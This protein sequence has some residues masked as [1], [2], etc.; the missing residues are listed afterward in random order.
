MKAALDDFLRKENSALN[1]YDLIAKKVWLTI[2]KP[3]PEAGQFARCL[4]NMADS[5]TKGDWKVFY[6]HP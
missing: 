3:E 1:K 4:K 6:K 2:D 5:F